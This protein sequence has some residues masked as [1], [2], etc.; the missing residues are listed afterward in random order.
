MKWICNWMNSIDLHATGAPCILVGIHAQKADPKQCRVQANC[1]CIRSALAPQ[2][3]LYGGHCFV[4]AENTTRDE[5]IQILKQ[6]IEE[7]VRLDKAGYID[8]VV[9][10]SW[11]Q[12]ADK[13]ME[14]EKDYLRIE[15][16][17]NIAKVY[18][19]VVD[20]KGQLLFFGDHGTFFF[21]Q[22]R[23]QRLQLNDS[24]N[25]ASMQEIGKD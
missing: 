23:Y 8:R 15:E 24:N 6:N 5:N 16:I 12:V 11:R 3:Q 19:N 17:E 10:H 20:V 7:N 21:Y 13:M 2:K 22:L 9:P 18:M 25:G 14:T 4:L 1:W